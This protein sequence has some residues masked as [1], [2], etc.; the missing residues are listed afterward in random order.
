MRRSLHWITAFALATMTV[1][2]V[3]SMAAEPQSAL[4]LE[5]TI[6]LEGVR[7][8]ID[9][10]AVDL[11]RKR[12]FVAELGNGSVDVIDLREGR[13]IHRLP[14]LHEPQGVGYASAA[15]LIAVA[16]AGDGTVRMFRGEDFEPLGSIALGDDADNI[17]IDPR[18]GVAM[19]GY[20]SGGLAVI[21]PKSRTKIA[22]ISLPAHPEGFQIDPDTGHAFVN[23]PDAGQIAV[24]DLE[25]RRQVAAWRVPGL[26]ANFPMALDSARSVLATVFRRPSRLAL[27]D[28][29]TGSVMAKLPVCADADDVFFD[30]NRERI[31]VSCGAGEIAVFRRDGG[32]YR[33]L[34]S[35]A[36]TSGARTSLFVPQLD[37][38]FVAERAGLLGSSAAIAVFRP[39]P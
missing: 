1:P 2:T 9:H 30:A 22:G 3:S 24:V 12:L 29:R 11:G 15:N 38:L 7:G 16:N 27:L 10:L 39:V 34:T 36:T 26:S 23:V 13:S 33:P 28:A 32:N 17:R 5:S 25:R 18:T 6:P 21:D 4:V 31:Y 14:G 19:V 35:V 8:R 20:G 37:R